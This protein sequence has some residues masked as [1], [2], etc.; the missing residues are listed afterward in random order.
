[1]AQSDW[2]EVWFYWQLVWFYW[3]EVWF[4]PSGFTQPF[5]HLLMYVYFRLVFCRGEAVRTASSGCTFRMTWR[6]CWREW[7]VHFSLSPFWTQASWGTLGA[8][9]TES[10]ANASTSTARWVRAGLE[11]VYQS[12]LNGNWWI[13]SFTSVSIWWELMDLEFYISQ[14]LMG[15]DGSW[16]L[17]QSAFD[18]NWWILSFTSVS[19]WWELMDLEFYISQHL[20]GTDGSWV[21]R[22]SALNRNL[23]ILSFT[24]NNIAWELMDLEIYIKQHWMG[25][26]GSWVLP[27]SIEWELLDLEFG[28]TCSCLAVD[29]YRTPD[30]LL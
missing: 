11:V 7:R 22:Q 5:F 8:S 28:V 18:G 20:M 2:Q 15:T 30:Y 4:W 27:V 6:S 21:L 10:L 17:H 12:A 23:W 16:V 29:M 13:L 25:T 26:D 24:S 14:H 3:Q 1:M 9:W 19:I